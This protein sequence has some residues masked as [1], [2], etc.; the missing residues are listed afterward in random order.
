MTDEEGRDRPMVDRIV[1]CLNAYAVNNGCRGEHDGVCLEVA[2]GV[3]AQWCQYCLMRESAKVVT[4]L[5]AEIAAFRG[6]TTRT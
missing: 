3:P 6:D 1:E 4:Q 2:P 5:R